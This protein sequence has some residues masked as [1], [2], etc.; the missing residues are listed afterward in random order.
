MTKQRLDE[1][2]KA[3]CWEEGDYWAKNGQL[4]ARELCEALHKYQ[5]EWLTMAQAGKMLGVSGPT[6][7]KMVDAGELKGFKMGSAHRRVSRA[8][9]M[10]LI[11]SKGD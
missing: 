7:R 11:G 4:I 1:I 3:V 9:I 5:G 2:W 6:I 10:K 8:E